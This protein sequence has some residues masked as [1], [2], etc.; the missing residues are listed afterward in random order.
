MIEDDALRFNQ[1]AYDV[2]R[3]RMTAAPRDL[4]DSDFAQLE[5]VS[6]AL[7]TEA[8]RAK[9][10]AL[11]DAARPHVPDPA[12]TPAPVLTT[13]AAPAAPEC[14]DEWVQRYGAAPVTGAVLVKACD[15]WIEAMTAQ[16]ARVDALL[17]RVLELE[18]TA[19][20]RQ[21]STMVTVSKV[22]A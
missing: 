19:A 2:A 20:A 21:T 3:A 9:G 4:T 18:A 8:H 17:E 22:D 13:S 15:A 11:L 5:C 1:A 10:L 6:H 7:A 16:K 12:S 14:M